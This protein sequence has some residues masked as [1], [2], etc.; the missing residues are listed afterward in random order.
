MVYPFIP[1]A[2][3]M[4][5]RVSPIPHLIIHQ[6]P[7]PHLS[8]RQFPVPHPIIHQSP[9][10][11]SSFVPNT[12]TSPKFY[13]PSKMPHLSLHQS[14][15]PHP[16][17]HQ[18][19]LPHSSFVLIATTSPKFHKVSKM[20]HPKK[21]NSKYLT[22]NFIIRTASQGNMNYLNCTYHPNAIIHN[23]SRCIFD[24]LDYLASFK[25]TI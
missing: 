25:F 20:P 15:V 5:S 16:I 18:S 4:I 14:P 6:F 10:P 3:P 7:L 12:T 23:T 19:P 13:K 9:L 2:S 24:H 8:Q 21:N 17:I 22:L 11:H 1:F